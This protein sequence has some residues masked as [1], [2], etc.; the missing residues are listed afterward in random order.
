MHPIENIMK[1]TM[2]EIKAMVDVNTI[3]GDPILTG[4]ETMILPVSKVSLGFLSGGGEYTAGAAKKPVARSGLA[5][6]GEKGGETVGREYPFAG[7]AVAGMSLTPMAFLSV[8][9]GCVKVLPAQY[10]NS[11]DRVIDLLPEAVLAVERIVCDA[12]AAAN[13]NQNGAEG[14]DA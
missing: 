7:T 11:W 6:D 4:T 10:H 12:S 2:E 13:N 14:T 9:G 8:N 1:S 5:L 3:V